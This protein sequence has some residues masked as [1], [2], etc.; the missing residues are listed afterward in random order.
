[1]FPKPGEPSFDV[2]TKCTGDQKNARMLGLT[3]IDG[4]KR[5]GLEYKDGNI[6]DPRDGS[7]YHAQME[8][9]PDGKTLAVRGYLFVPLLGQTQTWHRLPD[10]ALAPQDVPKE[11]LATPAAVK[12]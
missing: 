9:S 11:V 3:M 2:C 7:V 5:Y 1:M 6:L 4:M 8:L 10:D 12:H